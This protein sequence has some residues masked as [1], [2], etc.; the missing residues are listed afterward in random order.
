MKIKQTHVDDIQIE[1]ISE[2]VLSDKKP[3]IQD[4][5][6][7]SENIVANDLLILNSSGWRLMHRTKQ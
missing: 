5:L 6:A 7:E 4:L 1:V 3:D 2:L